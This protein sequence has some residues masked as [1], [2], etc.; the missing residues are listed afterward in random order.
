MTNSYMNKSVLLLAALTLLGWP[1][2]GDQVRVVNGTGEAAQIRYE[3]IVEESQSSSKEI[4]FEYF[5][6]SDDDFTLNMLA[7][8]RHMAIHKNVK[9]KMLVDGM[10]GEL[11]QRTMAALMEGTKGNLQIRIF[12]QIVP[13]SLSS[14]T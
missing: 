10:F 13:W 2:F 1:V 14:M 4:L 3:L 5:N 7:Y 11:S 9:V 8:L 12:N 6:V